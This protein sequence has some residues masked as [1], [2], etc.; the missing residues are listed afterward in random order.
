[1]AGRI[2][3]LI[4][5]TAALAATRWVR[6]IAFREHQQSQRYEDVYYL[7]S[8]AWLPVMSLGYRQA[9]ADLLWCRSLVYFGQELSQRG[10]VRYVFEYTDAI[11]AL[12]PSFRQ[13][14]RWVATAALY[15]PVDTDVEVGL[16]AARYLEEAVRRW[17]EDGELEWDYGSLLRFELAPIA[18]DAAQRNA[19]YERAAPH[20]EAAARLGAGPP[21][22]ALISAGLL[23]RLGRT[24]QAIQHLEE[25]Y[26]TA[27]DD[28]VR[29]ELAARL[30]VLRGQ[31]D[32]E[33]VRAAI[34]EFEQS[35]QRSYPYLSPDLFLWV[36]PRP[37]SEAYA[38]LLVDRFLDDGPSPEPSDE[39]D[40]AT[41]P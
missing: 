27:S 13:A 10:Q 37:S 8:A 3:L 23:N 39:S 34:R 20:L 36:G 22:L 12:D 5:L 18:R 40:R 26:A 19:L 24:E 21:W 16:R 17:P 32:M 15:R 38:R 25:I 11:L 28:A 14:Y 41:S 7:P 6:L 31:R 4:A 2:V 30:T 1:M 9:L 29:A 33:A 35:H